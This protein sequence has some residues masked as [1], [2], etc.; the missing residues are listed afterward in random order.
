MTPSQVKDFVDR[1]MP[2]YQEYLPQLYSLP[3][4]TEK[5]ADIPRVVAT[6]D[7]N[8]QVISYVEE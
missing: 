6:I 3:S 4:S 5:L 7:I 8:R 1:F 2:V